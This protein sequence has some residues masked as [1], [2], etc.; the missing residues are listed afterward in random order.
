MERVGLSMGLG[1]FLAGVLLASSEYRHALES[2]ILPFKGL[3]LGLFFIAVGM[4]M[5]LGLLLDAP[6]QV[7][8]GLLAVVALKACGLWLVARV[9]GL[10]GRSGALLAALLSQVGEFAFVVLA[11]AKVSNALPAND[12]DLLTLIAA[13]SMVSTPL[14]LMVYDRWCRAETSEREADVMEDEHT[15]VLLAGFGRYGQT[16]GRMLL[17]AGIKP[18]VIDHDANTV[19]AARRFGFKV[20]FGDATQPDL[21]HAAGAA[22]ARVLVIAIDDQAQSM[23]LVHMLRSQFPQLKIVARARDALHAMELEEQ[24][25]HHAQREVFESSLRSARST[26]E[27]LGFDRFYARQMADNFRRYSQQFLKS[28]IAAR[29]D[30]GD[31]I[32][33]VRQAREQFEQEM[34]QDLQRQGKRRAESGW[35]RDI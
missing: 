25:V 1:A 33:R 30:E 6:G 21:L 12:A 5:Q 2:D 24:Q 26:L 3:L 9:M 10:R 16:V 17:G 4:S 13:L 31:L 23:Q 28:A 34:Q 19:D 18:T 20:Y 32:V 29:H 14:L 27:L 11:A 35:Q 22:K 7:L 15:P 8:L